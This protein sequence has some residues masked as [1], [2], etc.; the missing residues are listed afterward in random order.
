MMNIVIF[1]I[2][3]GEIVEWVPREDVSTMITHCFPD[4]EEIVDHSLSRSET[5][6]YNAECECYRVNGKAFERMS[7]QGTV[8]NQKLLRIG[9]NPQG[10]NVSRISDIEPMMDSMK[11]A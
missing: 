5:A 3:A 2:V 1:A 10:R 4:A 7:V 8:T 11:I 9:V 6:D